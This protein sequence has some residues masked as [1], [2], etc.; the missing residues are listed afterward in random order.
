MNYTDDNK[1]L[2]VD[3][4][5]AERSFRWSDGHQVGFVF[6]LEDPPRYNA[7][8][9]YAILRLRTACSLGPQPVGI[10]LNDQDLANVTISGEGEYDIRIS[11]GLMHKGANSLEFAIPRAH[12]PGTDDKRV[13]GICLKDLTILPEGGL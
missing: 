12:P 6:R 10:R 13:L 5:G 1:M 8:A 7:T 4:S 3:W 11:P 9:K 2:F